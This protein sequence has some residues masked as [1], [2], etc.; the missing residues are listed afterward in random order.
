MS[1]VRPKLL[2]LFVH[3]LGGGEGTWG[4]FKAL[5]E[6][7]ESLRDSVETAFFTFPTSALRIPFVS[8]W[9]SLPIQDLADALRT[10]I[11]YKY[12]SYEKIIL[13]THSLGGLVGK[14]YL[15]DALKASRPLRVV[16]VLF[17]ATPHTGAEL[18][19][20][21]SALS[22]EHPHLR[23][24][25]TN[26]DFATLVARDWI[27]L[28]CESKVRT[29]YIVAGQD[30]I[31][32][33]ESA[34]GPP[35]ASREV[36]PRCG[37]IDVVKPA[38]D[39]DISFLIVRR[40]AIEFLRDRNEELTQLAQAIAEGNEYAAAHLVASKGRSWI[41][42][43]ESDR[44]IEL[45]GQVVE[46]FQSSSPAFIWSAYLMALARLFRF[47]ENS[48]T[49]FDRISEHEAGVLGLRPLIL[50]EKMEFARKRGDRNAALGFGNE[51]LQLLPD[52]EVPSEAGASYAIGT[53]HFILGNLLRFGGNYHQA[54][55]A[56]SKARRFFR[57]TILSHQ[58]ELAH[59]HYAL[60]ICSSM[61][62]VSHEEAL[63]PAIGPEL[64]P[65]AE[66]LLTLVNSHSEWAM[67]RLSEA[68]DLA[69]HASEAF[70][71]IRY[72]SYANRAQK[73]ESLLQVWR[74]LD[75]G[76]SPDRAV[77]LAPDHA[78]LV[79][80]MLGDQNARGSLLDHI[81]VMR[82]SELLGLLQFASAYNANW[83]E[84]IG[85]LRHP[86]VLVLEERRLRWESSRSYSL[87]D[88]DRK[89]R[90]LMNVPQEILV[91]LIAD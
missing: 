39:N 87:A 91:P 19:S 84:N 77:A 66:A 48:S 75:L 8:S 83:A 46:R 71:Q 76:G 28:K 51:L 80:A 21:A 38:S 31:V 30:A 64:R 26:S 24:L 42:T 5:I 41:E 37:H 43:A 68:A 60:A 11:D 25:K 13:V 1:K 82:P 73:L 55:L 69:S 36:I 7:D 18:A 67:G 65:F 29:T 47:R 70:S 89:L 53:A 20:A 33:T 6:A 16:A 86:P 9:I 12:G 54:K 78:T 74:R 14:H 57:P 50:A 62:G 85:E 2:L 27:T 34:S 35:G 10:E 44:A 45:F 58:I 22:S 17:F 23:Q 15:I 49:A 32:S 61:T 40:I 3:G 79:R 90:L 56:I 52:D 63:A 59:C 72:V 81:H 4:A 88:C